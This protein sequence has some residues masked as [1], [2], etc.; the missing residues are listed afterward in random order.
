MNQKNMKSNVLLIIVV[1][2]LFMGVG[3]HMGGLT[4]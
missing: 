1:W 3:L 2:S 4:V